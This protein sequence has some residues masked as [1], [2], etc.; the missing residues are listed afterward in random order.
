ML[1]DDAL[2][3]LTAAAD[4]ELSP[5]EARAVRRLLGGSA[6]A[7]VV[8][9]RLTADRARVRQLAAVT[10]PPP[11]G[12]RDRIMARLPAA[13]AVP[14]PPDLSTPA[15]ARRKPARSRPWVPLAVAAS[16]LLAVTGGSFWFFTRNHGGGPATARAR[17]DEARK[18]TPTA[19]DSAWADIL[20]T[21]N[22]GLPSAPAVVELPDSAVASVAPAAG[23]PEPGD[24]LPPPRPVR[25][26]VIAFP[27]VPDLPPL[28]LVQVRVPFL[29][30]VADFD[31][32]DV[33]QRFAE[34]LDHPAV[35]IDLF[36][37]DSARGVE[38]VLAAARATGLAVATD[39]ATAER[40]KRKQA[41]AYLLYAESLTATD[42]RTLITALAAD[43]AKNPQRVFDA[44]HVTPAGPSE[45]KELKEILGT[46]PGLWKRPAAGGA[47]G[48]KP[49]SAAT[50]DQVARNLAGS[51]PT[52]GDKPAVLMTHSPAAYRTNP[53]ASREVKQFFDRRGER[54]PAAVP[55]LIVIR[56]AAG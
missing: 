27:P 1:P 53:A 36:V 17:A 45:H 40:M 39:A 16:L 14:L 48:T 25:R 9:E 50:A 13:D 15:P 49:I 19:G 24:E 6:E 43:D 30:P 56:Q 51:S 18:L 11:A 31:R 33:R 38:A 34:E 20:P 21:E 52:A 22:G 47:G 29:A 7:R 10:V 26:D 35:R 44:A 37:K 8:H 41:T 23:R 5:D 54:K 46:D 32:E 55:V 12:L 28:N 42:I 3:L 2:H 4:G